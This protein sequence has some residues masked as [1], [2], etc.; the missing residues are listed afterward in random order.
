M[1]DPVVLLRCS[2]AA[3]CEQSWVNVP[4]PAS[5]AALGQEPSHLDMPSAHHLMAQGCFPAG[6]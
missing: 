4:G 5:P 2:R 3:W 6:E 1:A